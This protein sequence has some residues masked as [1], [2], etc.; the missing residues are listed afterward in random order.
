MN[1]ILDLIYINLLS[2]NHD[3]NFRNFR[4]LGISILRQNPFLECRIS[5][6]LFLCMYLH[7]IFLSL[8][9]VL[10]CLFRLR[11]D[12]L[13]VGIL[14]EISI[15]FLYGRIFLIWWI[16]RGGLIGIFFFFSRNFF[17]FFCCF[18][19]CFIHFWCLVF[20]ALFLLLLLLLYWKIYYFWVLLFFFGII[21][22]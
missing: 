17:I 1:Q 7:N 5:D 14:F 4:L 10:G 11:N 2:G 20:I 21:I 13:I 6:L 18:F 8:N 22:N 12:L 3:R 19:Y 9:N 16:V 15:L